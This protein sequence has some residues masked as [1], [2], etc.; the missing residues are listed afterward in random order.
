M[1]LLK[2]KTVPVS[3]SYPDSAADAPPDV[4]T[5]SESDNNRKFSVHLCP[6]VQI[7]IS[8]NPGLNLKKTYTVDPGLAL[9]KL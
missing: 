6:V 3:E 7:W 1:P 9:I 5:D 4:S 8:A 2:M